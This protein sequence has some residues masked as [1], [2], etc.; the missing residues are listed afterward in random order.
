[1]EKCRFKAKIG[2]LCKTHHN[3]FIIKENDRIKKEKQLK[4]LE[5]AEGIFMECSDNHHNYYCD[6]Y[7]KEKV[8]V[9]LFQKNVGDNRKMYKNCLDC[10]NYKAES[11]KKCRKELKELADDNNQ[12]NEQSKSD[13]RFCLSST[14]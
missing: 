11:A 1:L 10:R 13:F 9:E 4:E 14:P 7:P 2:N 3:S 8:P 5:E 6:K 12:E